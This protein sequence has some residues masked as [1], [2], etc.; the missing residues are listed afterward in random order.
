MNK[1]SIVLYKK[2][3]ADLHQR[4]EEHFAIT[5]FD[6]ITDKNR[7]EVFDAL[8]NAEGLLGSGGKIDKEDPRACENEGSLPLLHMLRPI[9]AEQQ[10]IQIRHSQNCW[11][12]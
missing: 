1:P 7:A 2:L 12:P 3:P 11:R 6:G 5:E 8:Q 9:S 10:M 4:L